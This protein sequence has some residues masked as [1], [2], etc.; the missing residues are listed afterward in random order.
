MVTFI[1]VNEQDKDNTIPYYSVSWEYTD[2]KGNK[3][4]TGNSWT[5][6]THAIKVYNQMV[7]EGKNPKA[8][9]RYIMGFAF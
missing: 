5:D 2:K 7:K 3:R 9:M 6:K 4:K 8:S 1:A